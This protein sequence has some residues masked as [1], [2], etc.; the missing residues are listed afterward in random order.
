MATYRAPSYIWLPR[1][2]DNPRAIIGRTVPGLRIVDRVA[3]PGQ[4]VTADD[5]AAW[6]LKPKDLTDWRDPDPQT[7]KEAAAI[8]KQRAEGA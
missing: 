2:E 7:D 6:G 3:S 1:G 8:M 5:L 4:T